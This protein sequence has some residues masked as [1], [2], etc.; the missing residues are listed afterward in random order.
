MVLPISVRISLCLMYHYHG[1]YDGYDKVTFLESP[2][3]DFL[4]E[5]P[6]NSSLIELNLLLSLQALII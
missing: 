2:L 5:G 4:I 6:G 1:S 3:L